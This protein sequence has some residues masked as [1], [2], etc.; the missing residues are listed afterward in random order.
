MESTKREGEY[1]ALKSADEKCIVNVAK[2]V[3]GY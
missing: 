1:L 2:E 3:Q